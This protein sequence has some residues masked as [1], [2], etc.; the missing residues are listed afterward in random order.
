[1][2]HTCKWTRIHMDDLLKQISCVLQMFGDPRY[3]QIFRGDS[4]AVIAPSVSLKL[5][6]Q[7][8]LNLV[9]QHVLSI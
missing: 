9:Q 8:D 6:S 4:S 1:M 2:E 5:K 7:S 3:F